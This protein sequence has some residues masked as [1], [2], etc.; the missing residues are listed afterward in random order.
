MTL[1]YYLGNTYVVFLIID[2][3]LCK[4]SLKKRTEVL[5]FIAPLHHMYY[6]LQPHH[7]RRL[8]RYS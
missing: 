7:E 6:L 8:L 1:F 4:F 5:F 2:L 3:I